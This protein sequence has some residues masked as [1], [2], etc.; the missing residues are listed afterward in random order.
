MSSKGGGGGGEKTV[1]YSEYAV[2]FVFIGFF[3]F[4]LLGLRL[5]LDSFGDLSI[6]FWTSARNYS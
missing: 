5:Q 3:L 2:A 6:F 1:P 4:F